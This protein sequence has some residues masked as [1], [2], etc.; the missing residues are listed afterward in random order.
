MPPRRKGTGRKK[1]A[2]AKG[3]KRKPTGRKKATGRK[4]KAPTR[5]RRTKRRAVNRKSANPPKARNIGVVIDSAKPVLQFPE[6]WYPVAK[7]P[8]QVTARFSSDSFDFIYPG[9][10][11]VVYQVGRVI[12]EGSFGRVSIVHPLNTDN[13]KQWPAFAL[14]EFFKM[15]NDVA[16]EIELTK[17]PKFRDVMIPAK[18]IGNKVLM[19]LGVEIRDA[20]LARGSDGARVSDSVASAVYA[21]QKK[22]INQGYIYTDMKAGNVLAMPVPGSPRKARIIFAD[23]GGLCPIKERDCVYTYMLPERGRDWEFG[24]DTKE[25]ALRAA[26]WWAGLV[27]LQVSNRGGD[28]H[29]YVD[30]P[31]RHGN[32]GHRTQQRWD[33]KLDKYADQLKQNEGFG[34]IDRYIRPNPDNRMT[35]LY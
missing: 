3:R 7:W 8:V 2:A 22:L 23:Y 18:V 27:G 19:Q 25:D 16:M 10:D 32:M 26:R 29:R 11:R 30:P 17:N 24:F 31:K 9:G 21:M 35:P 34:V 12:G 28:Y 4:R 20:D 5:R 1:P 15:D 13:R 33:R 14:K 6:E